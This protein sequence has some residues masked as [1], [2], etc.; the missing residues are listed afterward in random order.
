M[1]REL[2]TSS[3]V[4]LPAVDLREPASLL[5]LPQ[6]LATQVARVSDLG[7][8]RTIVDPV[9]K[10]VVGQVATIPKSQM[11]TGPQRLAIAQR[12]EELQAAS[13]PGPTPRLIG[14]LAEL[15]AEYAT[16]RLDEDT[17]DIKITAY[18]D[19]VE[20]L[21]A[22]AVREAIRRWRRGDVSGDTRDLDFA[23]KPARLRR[24]AQGIAATATGQAIRLQ[25]ILDAEAEE[26]IS[27]AEREANAKRADDLAKQIAAPVIA[28]NDKAEREAENR[29]LAERL[30][31]SEATRKAKVGAEQ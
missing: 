16:A 25:R 9:T 29:A 21:P 23:P 24:I 30:A 31:A 8:G 2:Q 22:W 5:L 13:R 27:E 20:D 7:Y 18:R 1:G 12:I 11:P 10:A 6:W 14:I 3:P 4:A 28:S 17:A 26:P 19:A 15:V